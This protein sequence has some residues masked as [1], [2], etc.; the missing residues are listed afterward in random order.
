MSGVWQVEDRK[1]RRGPASLTND[2]TRAGGAQGQRAVLTHMC[3]REA[4]SN[5]LTTSSDECKA[6]LG[7]VRELRPKDAHKTA[8]APIGSNAGH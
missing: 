5:T 7:G 4:H 2:N 3:V 8:K 1:P 6:A